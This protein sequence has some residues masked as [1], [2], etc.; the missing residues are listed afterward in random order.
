M[1]PLSSMRAW[2]LHTSEM[3]SGGEMQ[4]PQKPHSYPQQKSSRFVPHVAGNSTFWNKARMPNATLLRIS[5]CDAN[6]QSK[7]PEIQ[8]GIRNC[9]MAK[10][11]ALG[12]FKLCSDIQTPTNILSCLH[13]SNPPLMNSDCMLSTLPLALHIFGFPVI[14]HDPFLCPHIHFV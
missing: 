10:Q 14:F 2:S 5:S 13:I 3:P 6:A 11:H 9:L 1:S 7:V 12:K 8:T 4:N